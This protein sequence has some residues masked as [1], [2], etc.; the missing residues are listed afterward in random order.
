MLS[1][2]QT[3]HVIMIMGRI[4]LAV[5]FIESCVDKFLH[6]DFYVQE[7]AAKHI[8]F[9]SIA[10]ALAAITE[11]AGSI[12]LLTG[13]GIFYAAFALAGYI[14]V[15]NFFYFDF[16][17]QIDTPAI[18]ARKEFLKNLAVI[19]GLMFAAISNRFSAQG[20]V[21]VKQVSGH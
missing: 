16:W 20:P 18:M 2:E 12:S 7:T 4:L 15:V 17:N 8:P 1:R 6:W 13:M 14:F 21:A 3:A 19:G 10:L 9:P 11:F 5:M